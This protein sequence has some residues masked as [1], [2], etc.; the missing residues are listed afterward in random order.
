ML[1][2]L[3]QLTQQYTR[4]RENQRYH[5]DYLLLHIRRLLLDQARRLCDAGVLVEPFEVFFLEADELEQLAREPIA[6]GAVRARI[7]ERRDHYERWKD[8]LPAT[9]LFDDVET[10]GEI[11]EGDRPPDERRG[12]TAGVGASRGR[13]RG[14][15]RVTRSLDELGAVKPGEIL[16]ANNIDPG[17][18]SVFP[19]LAG[20]V[21]ETGGMLSHGALLAREY[22]IPAVM[23]VPGAT[24]RFPTGAVIAI[25]GA[26]SIPSSARWRSCSYHRTDRLA[27]PA[28]G[29][30][31]HRVG[32]HWKAHEPA[33]RA[34]GREPAH[35]HLV[36]HRERAADRAHDDDGIV[37]LDAGGDQGHLGNVARALHVEDVALTRDA[38]A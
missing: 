17:W 38:P 35:A 1:R 2:R 36:G 5:L 26:R 16:V 4:Y 7:D 31:A 29:R 12:D 34:A 6:T 19:L 24:R 8:R 20:L 18:T 23:G 15:V 27:Q 22:G 30:S 21:T 10:E 13:A 37:F 32:W 28:A 9:F 14:P 25:D 33:R 11:V 3:F